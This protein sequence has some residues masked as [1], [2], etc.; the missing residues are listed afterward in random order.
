MLSYG[1]GSK[2]NHSTK[3]ISIHILSVTLAALMAIFRDKELSNSVSESALSL[4]IEEASTALLDP[5]LGGT[6][7]DMDPSTSTQLVKAINKLAI[8]SAIGSKRLNSLQ[9]LLS[10]QLKFSSLAATLEDSDEERNMNNRLSRI[11]TKL[12]VRV[13]KLE[14]SSEIPFYREGMKYDE[15]LLPLQNMLDASDVIRINKGVNS[16]CELFGTTDNK[17]APMFSC[18]A[19][20][21]SLIGSFVKADIST[22]SLL[23]AM[24]VKGIDPHNSLLARL[25]MCCRGDEFSDRKDF[26]IEKSKETNYLVVNKE[27]RDNNDLAA[28]VS[29]I[30]KA[31]EGA[32]RSEAL[33][34]LRDYS[35]LH[36]LDIS[37]HLAHLS[38]P[39]Q[40]FILQQMKVLGTNEN[41]LDH[42]T[43]APTYQDKFGKESRIKY[44]NTGPKGGAYIRSDSSGNL[45]KP[46][47]MSERIK[48]L[49]SKL[50]ATEA[51]VQ[52]A[53]GSKMDLH[54]TP[55]RN[56]N[57]MVQ[58]FASASSKNTTGTS[59][60]E[61][62]SVV[63]SETS[64]ESNSTYMSSI[65][66]RL[67]A[68]QEGR[69]KIS[70]N[71]SV[72]SL[73]SRSTSTN[74]GAAL[75]ARLEAAKRNRKA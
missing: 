54:L 6:S 39:F 68:T 10:L 5:R 72:S 73:G 49:K 24:K 61:N 48:F 13:T 16:C 55:T 58:K 9:A 71:T 57:E 52:S 22:A 60:I 66:M 28:L 63:Q 38:T 31:N 43:Q 59:C 69:R 67:A 40:A 35:S 21:T 2:K 8:Q 29:A 3:S 12:F 41:S 64:Q 44:T 27:A 4:L 25:L 20:A 7:A 17:N 23:E 34:A 53:M 18:V 70:S 62:S 75:R 26:V 37:E 14:E 42:T 47:A 11:I 51:A 36:N 56:Q 65:R 50:N 1:F 33:L 19:M 45:S 32:E 46:R 30:G 74:Q 15:L